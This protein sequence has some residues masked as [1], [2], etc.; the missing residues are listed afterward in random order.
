MKRKGTFYALVGL[1]LLSGPRT[2]TAAERPNVV[3]TLS[4]FGDLVQA[5]G[6]EEVQVISI[7]SPKF[8]PHFIEPKPSD[9]LKTKRA[10]LFV[11]AG[12]DLEL[13]RWPLLDAAGNTRLFQGQPGELDL[14]RGIPLLEIPTRPLSRAEGDIHLYGNPHYWLS[15]ENVKTMAQAVCDKLCAIDPQHQ[16]T[17]HANLRAFLARLDRKM[18]EWRSALA[19]Y[20]GREVVG[21][22]N[23]WVY[24]MDFAGLRMNHFLEPK[25]GI[26]PTPQ[27]VQFITQHITQ[28]QIPAIV[29]E[30]FFP[31]QTAKTIAKR[32]GAQVVL[33]CQNVREVPACSDYIAMMDY[34]VQQLIGALSHAEE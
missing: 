30:S 6:G 14:S 25:P 8:N 31:S 34:N 4:T 18:A 20:N 26:P 1:L 28:Q 23:S 11:H 33:L 17:Y 15:P 22:H 2:G 10:A 3:T 16:D 32:T 19:P 27:Q 5:I 29:Q 9:V 21:Y 13:W 24:L 7:A 12:L